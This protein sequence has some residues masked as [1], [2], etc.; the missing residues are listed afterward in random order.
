MVQL[1]F[2]CK[3]IANSYFLTFINLILDL[4]VI[5]TDWFV[6]YLLFW[7]LKPCYIILE[8]EC[9]KY[10]LVLFIC[11][12]ICLYI[13]KT[14]YLTKMIAEILEIY[15][16]HTAFHLAAPIFKKNEQFLGN[17]S[18]YVKVII[19]QASSR[20]DGYYLFICYDWTAA[21]AWKSAYP[22][23]DSK[24]VGLYG[25]DSSFFCETVLI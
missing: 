7:L 5:F 6:R 2:C 20:M 16:E 11:F 13:L 23:T 24:L 25:C 21:L 8:L 18:S 22:I 15:L 1:N 4:F 19:L 10:F 17:Y 14:H 3:F 12:M 9:I